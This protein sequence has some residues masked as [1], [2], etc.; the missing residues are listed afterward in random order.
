MIP[1]RGSPLPDD[2]KYESAIFFDNDENKIVNVNDICPKITT[3]KVPETASRVSEKSFDSP[4]MTSLIDKAGGDHNIYIHLLKKSGYTSDGFDEI[5]G[6][7]PDIHGPIIKTWIDKR[8]NPNKNIILIDWDR[9]TTVVEGFIEFPYERFAAY[10]KL[11]KGDFYNDYLRYLCGG[12]ERLD[13]IREILDYAGEKGIDI[14]ILTN[15]TACDSIIFS[16]LVNILVPSSVENLF[17]ICSIF[18][19][20]NGHKG[21]KLKSMPQFSNLCTNMTGGKRRR[22][23]S[24]RGPTRR[25][26]NRRNRTKRGRINKN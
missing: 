9:T 6:I 17:L 22:S 15:N 7:D 11:S 19:P 20:F 24:R 26:K 10:S 25:Y 13:K 16:E 5:S 1:I 21:L 4:L 18:P 3:I 8:E 23:R 2:E 12:D 14:G